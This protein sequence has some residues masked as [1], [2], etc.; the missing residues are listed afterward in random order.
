M[1]M[2][3]TA[4]MVVALTVAVPAAAQEPIRYRVQVDDPTTRLYRVSAELPATGDTTRVSLPAWTPG[5]YTLENYS[6]YV[7]SFE[8][9]DAASGRALGWDKQD[10]DTWRIFTSSAER[11]E[12]RLDYLADTVGLSLSLLRDDFGF[13][14]GTNF[15]VFPETGYDFPAEVTFDLPEGWA[16]ATEL[17]GPE[18]RGVYRASDYHEL[19]DNPTFVGRFAIDSVQADGRWIR[20]AV[21]PG[22]FLR[23]PAKRMALEALGRIADYQ[24]DLFGEPP[25]DRYTTLIYLATEP[26]QF[27][28][29][30]EHSNSH[31]DILPAVA[32]EQPTMV[33]PI[34]YRLLTHEYYHTWNVKRIR[35]AS[36]WP[37]AYD[38]QQPTP[39]LWVSEGITDYYAHVTLPRIGLNTE[40]DFW[41]SMR[42]AVDQ[43]EGQPVV[44]VEDAS[45]ETWIEPT[46][47]SLNYYYDKG[48]LLGLFLDIRIREATSNRRS[49]DD[50]MARLYRERYQRGRGF[51]TEDF[52]DYVA[53]HAGRDWVDDFY[54]R[55][56]DG[57]EPLPYAEMLAPA[58]IRFSADTTHEPFVGVSLAARDGQPVITFVEP[59]S[60]ADEAGL[61]AGDVL[62]RVG[63]V[64]IRDAGWANAFRRAYADS[65]G[66]P[67]TVVYERDGASRTASAPLGGRSRVEH[68]LTPDPDAG[69]SARAVRRGLVTGEPRPE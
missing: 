25:Y 32:F 65:V 31:L 47:I 52:L 33:F 69:E 24:H 48:A 45:L 40:D 36:L 62:R 6:R 37:Y 5:H 41:S 58:G 61:R 29:G 17:D 35:P 7:Q 9:L 19:V 63:A 54:R 46:R 64:E 53:E 50:V 11:V 4:L 55:Y 18:G 12:V 60:T 56:V 3:K 22:R 66:R 2:E 57:R 44:A 43:V 21:Y 14:N 28:G 34:V 15:F 42:D 26:I 30:L 27:F 67:L 10:Q 16:V 23:D 51:T 39:L 13:F 20:L 1:S 49:L 59:G 8:A 68:S 38:R